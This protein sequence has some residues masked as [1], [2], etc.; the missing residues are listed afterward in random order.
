MIIL[1]EVATKLERIL[2]S[3][4]GYTNPLAYYFQVETEGFHIDHIEKADKSG[5]FIPVFI[6]SLGGQFNPVRGLKQAT[7]SIPVV[8]YY[9]VRFKDD[10]YL[11]GEFLEE[12]FVGNKIN[13]GTVSG[14]AISNIS[15]PQ[16]GEIQN[17]D[18]TQFKKWINDNYQKQIEKMEPYMSM[19]FTLYLSNAAEG[20]LF[21]NDVKVD[22]TFTYNNVDYKI[23]DINIDGASVQSN[24]QPQSE[25][26]E[27]T[28]ES[29]SVP[30]STAYGSSFKFY[31]DMNKTIEIDVGGG[32]TDTRY[33]W[34]I[35]LEQWLSGNIQGIE[36]SLDFTFGDSAWN[37]KYTR[38]C[39]IQSIVVPIEKG[40]LL[41][42]TITLANKEAE[43]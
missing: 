6:S 3:L 14:S 34:R 26:E 19:Q 36:C 1:P 25:Q 29:F 32:V 42:F 39:F 2:N 20:L 28:P 15:V 10:F 12:V 33:P 37:L 18:F 13:Y 35:L 16:F 41:A 11:L 43:S 31:P 21:G 9:P 24:T 17:L 38:S 27:G 23:E 40:Q 8:L 5:N 4:D 22:F 30:F 7:Y